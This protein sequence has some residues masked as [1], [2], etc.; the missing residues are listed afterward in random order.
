MKGMSIELLGHNDSVS[1]SV[2]QPFGQLLL[3]ERTLFCL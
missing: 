1:Q 2:N 3:Y